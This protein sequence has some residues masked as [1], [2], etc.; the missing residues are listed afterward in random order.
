[1]RPWM[2]LATLLAS[3]AL[4]K[5]P[6]VAVTGAWARA[7]APGQHRTAAYMTLTSPVADQLV[8][9]VIPA[10]QATLHSMTMSGDV[11]RMR[12]LAHLTLPAGKPVALAPG[13]THI[14]LTGLGRPL[15]AG[16]A[17]PLTLHFAQAAP[18][19]VTVRILPLGAAGP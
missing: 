10:G 12:P 16:Q 13:G 8:G 1:M 11:M 6:P 5:T 9:V 7:T 3:P 2:L 19:T 18:E 4:A 14:M 15:L 17:I